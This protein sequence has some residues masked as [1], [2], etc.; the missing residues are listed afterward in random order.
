MNLA[1]HLLTYEMIQLQAV[2]ADRKLAVRLGVDRLVAAD[3]VAAAH[4][5][6]ARI[7]E[8]WS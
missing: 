1:S 3:L 5:F 4:A 2:A 8:L 6:K 7:A